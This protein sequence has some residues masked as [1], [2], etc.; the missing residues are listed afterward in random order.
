MPKDAPKLTPANALLKLANEW[1]L[2]IESEQFAKRMDEMDSF[3][4]FREMF[5]IPKKATLPNGKC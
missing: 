2:N 4:K 5:S 1:N 3:G